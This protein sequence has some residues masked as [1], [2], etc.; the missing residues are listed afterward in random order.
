MLRILTADDI[1]ISALLPPHALAAVA[2]L[3]DRAAHLHA[4]CLRHRLQSQP[5]ESRCE[6]GEGCRP[7]ERIAGARWCVDVRVEG[8]WAERGACEESPAE[9]EQEGA[10]EHFGGC[11]DGGVGALGR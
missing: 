5:V 7:R 3:L 4:A 11:V 8:A 10:G 9:G 6:V 2:Q 1:H